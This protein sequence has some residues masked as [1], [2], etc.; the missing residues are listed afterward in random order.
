MQQDHQLR[1]RL[2]FG[3]FE[4][5]LRA[6]ELRNYAWHLSLLGRYDEAIAEMRCGKSGST[7][8]RH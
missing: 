6:G 4:L 1:G 3:V 7:I 5:D 2:L 8:S